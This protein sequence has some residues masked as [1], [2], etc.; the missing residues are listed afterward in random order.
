M[1]K[2]LH[3]CPKCGAYTLETTCHKCHTKTLTPC[4]KFKM[5]FKQKTKF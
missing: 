2:Y 4:Y 1:F 3:K 5:I